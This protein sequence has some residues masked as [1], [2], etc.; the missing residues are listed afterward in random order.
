MVKHC[1]CHNVKQWS[2]LHTVL[3]SVVSVVPNG[4]HSVVLF[5]VP[6]AIR[7]YS[8]HWATQILQA[9]LANKDSSGTIGHHKVHVVSSMPKGVLVSVISIVSNQ[10]KVTYDSSIPQCI[11]NYF[12]FMER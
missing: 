2:N 9:T 5:V 12:E 6:N 10:L 3:I 8:Q 4:T 11:I 1:Q 7:Q